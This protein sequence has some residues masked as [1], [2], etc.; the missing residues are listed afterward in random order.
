M[1]NLKI[2]LKLILGFVIVLLMLLICSGVGIFN[3]NTM[4]AQIDQYSNRTVPNTGSVWEMRRNLVSIERY[5]LTAMM[6]EDQ[7]EINENLD[8]AAKDAQ[9][10]VSIMEVF[11]QNTR[12]DKESLTALSANLKKTGSLREQISDF[13]RKGE[14]EKGYHLF[15]TEYKPLFDE[16]AAMLVEIAAGQKQRADEQSDIAHGA[17]NS[18]RII[19]IV[20]ALLAVLITLIVMSILRKAILTPVQQIHLAAKAIARGD[21]SATITYDSKDELGELSNAMKTLVYTVVGIIKDLDYC[22]GEIGNGNFTVDSQAKELYIG[23]FAPLTKSLHQI[24]EQLSSTLSQINQSSDQV[25]SGSDQ[26]SA[27]AQALAQGAT[28]QA[29]SIEELSATIKEI[30]VK[31]GQTANNVKSA[32]SLVEETGIQVING[33]TKMGEMME[34]MSEISAKSNEISKIIKTIDAIAF[35]TNILALNAAVEAARAGAAGK[36]FAVVADEVRNLAQKSA[37]AAKNTTELIEG[38][39]VAVDK[40]VQIANE[41]AQSLTIVVTNAGLIT[42]R[43]EEIASDSMQQAAGASQIAIG[44]D[45]IAAVVQTNSATAEESAAASEEL[46]GQAQLLKDIVGKFK[47]GENT[48]Y[49]T[50]Y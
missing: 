45:Q 38:S 50:F 8:M 3:M 17:L 13:L 24:I 6:D 49:T 2:N 9:R 7:N 41:T 15:V 11:S 22:L 21:L 47:L 16:S 34:A 10:L 12:A 14:R 25:S 32:S 18:G 36:G 23:D 1:K 29:S 5:L 28:E 46:S 37:E 27:G 30:T 35:Q 40:G 31:I 4:G 42:Q 39:K 19:L 44:V 48:D 33:N 43:I 26:V 20:T